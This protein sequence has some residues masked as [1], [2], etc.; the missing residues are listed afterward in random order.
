M[1]KETKNAEASRQHAAAKRTLAAQ[2]E[3]HEANQAAHTSSKLTVSTHKGKAPHEPDKPDADEHRKVDKR[4]VTGDPHMETVEQKT[5]GKVTDHVTK[6]PKR[7]QP[8]G[9]TGTPLNEP[10]R[11]SQVVGAPGDGSGKG[12]KAAAKKAARKTSRNR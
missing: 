6:S 12:S 10:Q 3:E 7:A 11:A 8:G 5:L 4:V 2:N 9:G 1:A